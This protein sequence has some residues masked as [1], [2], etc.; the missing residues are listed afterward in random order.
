MILGK[1]YS[2]SEVSLLHLQNWDHC[3]YLTEL[4]GD[5]KSLYAH[6]VS[7]LSYC[8]IEDIQQC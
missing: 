8:H 7:Y 3:T 6:M 1:L 2:L 4:L 5:L